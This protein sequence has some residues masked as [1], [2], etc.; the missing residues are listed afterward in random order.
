MPN[1]VFHVTFQS[2]LATMGEAI[3]V[4][5]ACG[6]HGANESHAFRGR[7]DAAG[8]SMVLE[9]RHLCGENYPAFGC[10]PAVTLDLEVTQDTEEGFRAVGTIREA[11]GIKL[12][13]VAKRLCEL[14]G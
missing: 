13:V 5:D 7:Q 11:S 4:C 14:V 6:V 12:S 2:S 1:G 3:A 9:L 10:L 8:A